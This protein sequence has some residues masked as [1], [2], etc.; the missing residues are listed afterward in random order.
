VP[1]S[2]STGPT[3]GATAAWGLTV[4]AFFF[5]T[6]FCGAGFEGVDDLPDSA[7]EPPE[8]PEPEGAA[9]DDEPESLGPDE[10]DPEE[11]VVLES[12]GLGSVEPLVA[13]AEESP[14][15]LDG[16]SA[17]IAA[18]LTSVAT[19]MPAT[20]VAT[21]AMASGRR[22][23]RTARSRRAATRETCMEPLAT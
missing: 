12:D 9:E 20:I 14:A 21:T 13:L 2:V 5:A 17:A 4:G 8:E 11:L 7:E 18:P 6:A 16:C 10:L 23:R 1:F 3:A 19:Q 15:P 22:E